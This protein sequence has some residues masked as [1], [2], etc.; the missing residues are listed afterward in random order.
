M[1]T[2]GEQVCNG[3]GFHADLCRTIISHDGKSSPEFVFRGIYS[4]DKGS[5]A[6]K[7]SVRR[8]ITEIEQTHKWAVLWAMYRNSEEGT[9]TIRIDRVFRSKE[10]LEGTVAEKATFTQADEDDEVVVV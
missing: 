3:M 6:L 7:K 8:I 5:S 4:T 10:D 9:C 1:M 2:E